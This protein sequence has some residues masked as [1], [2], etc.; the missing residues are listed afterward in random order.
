MYQSVFSY[1]PILTLGPNDGVKSL[2]PLYHHYIKNNKDCEKKV[3]SFLTII[4]FPIIPAKGVHTE[5]IN[6][7]LLQEHYSDYKSKYR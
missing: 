5:C 3:F 4:F 7:K 1:M 6:C 2:N